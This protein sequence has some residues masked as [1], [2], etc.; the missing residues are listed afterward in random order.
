MLITALVAWFEV[1]FLDKTFSSYNIASFHHI[2]DD[3]LR[4][5]LKH[6]EHIHF[7]VSEHKAGFKNIIKS[8]WRRKLDAVKWI[9]AFTTVPLYGRFIENFRIQRS[10]ENTLH[11]YRIGECNSIKG[12]FKYR[13]LVT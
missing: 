2:Y 10:E 12:G 9:L 3:R 11:Y 1:F 13:N 4:E 7:G 8:D 5:I 6:F